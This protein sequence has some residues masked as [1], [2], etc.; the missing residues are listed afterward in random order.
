VRLG[1]RSVRLISPARGRVTI[2]AVLTSFTLLLAGLVSSAAQASASHVVTDMSGAKVTV[3]DKVTR[4]AEQFPAHTAMDI[5]L[6]VG[7]DLVAIP[8]NVSTI[9]FLRIVDPGIAK[10][11]QLFPSD[12]NV[13]IEELLKAKPDLVSSTGKGATVKQFAA[14]DLPAVDMTFTTFP[15]LIRSVRLAGS[16]Y[17][18]VANTRAAEYTSYLQSKIKM[19]RSTLTKAHLS[20]AQM[21]SV[22][23][24]ASYP[25]LVVD[26]GHS[27]VQQWI[28]TD[29]GTDSSAG[30]N[31]THISVSM[32]Q[33]LKWNPDVL[34]IETPGGDQGLVAN[35]AKSVLASLSKAAGWGDLKAVKDHQVYMDP[36]GL[37][38]WDRFGPE[39]ALQIQ[40]AAKVLHPNV[41]KS[42]NM[43]S[44]TR[45]FYQKFF[46]YNPTNAQL[47]DILQTT[48]PSGI[49]SAGT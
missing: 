1:L 33:L 17:G 27:I 12:G 23:H 46:D 18:G 2:V 16:V 44:V 38:P 49:A 41:F 9:P 47:S 8:Q 35:S 21:P 39:E 19:I 25:P 13:N 26:G 30:L 28:Q 34:I 5:M 14:V 45:D 43:R 31:G 36:Q 4:I 15:E 32:E 22:V 40:W 6:G 37:Y 20:R 7:K 29:G 48:S 10:V 24:I 3:P 42:L 11:P